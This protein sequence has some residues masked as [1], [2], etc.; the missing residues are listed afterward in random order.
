MVYSDTSHVGLGCVLMQDSKVVAIPL[1][2][3]RH[4]RGITLLMA[5][6]RHYLYGERCIIYTDH[7]S[8]K[9][10]LT[11]KELNLRQRRWV[12][13]LKDY[14]CIIEYHP[15]KANVVAE[16]LSSRAMSDLQAMFARLSLFDDGSL[17]AE[18]M[19]DESLFQRL[20]QV[21]SGEASKF[22]LN[23]DRVLCFRGQ[24]AHNSPYTMHLDGSKMYHDL[25][26]LYCWPELKREMTSFWNWERVTI[27]FA[28]GLPLMVAKKDSVWV[29]VDQLTKSTHFLPIRTDYSL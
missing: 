11:Q 25:R 5:V 24:E 4:I 9:Y 19:D 7:K 20:L 17:L 26:E 15:G 27:D 10:L 28:S 18:L 1:N 6:V 29:I 16:I 21:E 23:S 2:S 13:L 12:E 3:L 8:L 14:D 22:G